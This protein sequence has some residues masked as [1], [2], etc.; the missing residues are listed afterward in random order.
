MDKYNPL[1][2]KRKNNTKIMCSL[3]K[4]VTICFFLISCGGGG[5][6]SRPQA[7]TPP[8]INSYK[9][10]GGTVVNYEIQPITWSTK[11]LIGSADGTAE[12]D[13]ASAGLSSIDDIEIITEDASYIDID[14]VQNLQN[15]ATIGY[16]GDGTQAGSYIDSSGVTAD[17]MNALGLPDGK[18]T[19]LYRGGHFTTKLAGST[20]GGI[21]KIVNGPGNDLKIFIVVK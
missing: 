7:S 9:V 1:G 20:L 17:W 5:D 21:K 4:T 10:Y 2:V 13:I 3:I 15:N 8:Q 6:R 19:R 12:F 14:A 16:N 18:T 11:T